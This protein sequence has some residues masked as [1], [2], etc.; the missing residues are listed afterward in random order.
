MPADVAKNIF[1]RFYR[2]DGSRSRT[3]TGLG[4]AIVHSMVAA[5][6][7]LVSLRTEPGRGA[8]FTV[9]LPAAV[10]STDP[11]NPAGA[12]RMLQSVSEEGGP[13]AR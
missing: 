13:A 10:T 9:V 6:H 2:P 12:Y 3:G 1:E 8:Q 11:D 4:L 5:H 7:G